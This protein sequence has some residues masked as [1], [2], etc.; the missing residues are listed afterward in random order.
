M[1]HVMDQVRFFATI[2]LAASAAELT[3]ATIP[4]P[5]VEISAYEIALY[6][7]HLRYQL[8]GEEEKGLQLGV[9]HFR[10]SS[11]ILLEISKCT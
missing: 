9:Y 11:L 3:F 7:L 8:N 4:M 1:V 10:T 2:H 5:L 6:H